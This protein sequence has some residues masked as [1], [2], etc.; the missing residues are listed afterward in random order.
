[1]KEFVDKKMAKVYGPRPS[2]NGC[3]KT[4]ILDWKKNG[5]HKPESEEKEETDIDISP[6]CVD[7]PMPDIYGPPTDYYDLPLVT[8]EDDYDMPTDTPF[9]K[10]I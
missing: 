8:E 6:S 10:S 9:D 5:S 2:W 1:M 3:A 4:E 7:D